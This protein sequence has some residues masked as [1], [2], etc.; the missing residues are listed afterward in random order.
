MREGARLQQTNK[1]SLL[2]P[3]A[4][5]WLRRALQLRGL[6]SLAHDLGVLETTIEK[7]TD[8]IGVRGDALACLEAIITVR[9]RM[10]T[11]P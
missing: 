11:K 7:A 3:E 6:R 2:S 1:P 8:G 10:E 5:A 4:H 9:L